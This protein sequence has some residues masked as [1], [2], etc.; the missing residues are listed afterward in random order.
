M[1]FASLL[2]LLGLSACSN[3]R[4]TVIPDAG[5]AAPDG[6]MAMPDADAPDPDAGPA[7]PDAGG[8]PTFAELSSAI[9]MPRCAGCHD[10]DTFSPS[11]DLRGEAAHGRIVSVASSLP[12]GMSLVEPGDPDGSYL[13][14]KVAGTHGAICDELELPREDC[15]EQ[16][17]RGTGAVPLDDAELALVET[18]IATGAPP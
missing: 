1:R 12:G 3:E 8:G 15:G 14:R 13:Y 17:P 5:T 9:L 4:A 7:D 6:G 18:W 16:M 10:G 11:P 2:L